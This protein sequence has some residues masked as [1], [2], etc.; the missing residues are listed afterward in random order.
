MIKIETDAYRG[1]IDVAAVF[2]I[3]EDL[4]EAYMERKVCDEDLDVAEQMGDT[5]AFV[6]LSERMDI[7]EHNIEVLEAVLPRV[8]PELARD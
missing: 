7:I 2:D 6:R 4:Y 5:V 8:N 1:E 3:G